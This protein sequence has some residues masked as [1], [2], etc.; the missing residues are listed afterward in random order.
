MREGTEQELKKECVAL[1]GTAGW[2]V[3][4]EQW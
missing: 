3:A 2:T 1:R 4:V